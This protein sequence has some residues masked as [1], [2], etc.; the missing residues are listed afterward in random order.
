[1]WGLLF[2]SLVS[3]R[4]LA[5]AVGGAITPPERC[6]VLGDR[7]DADLLEAQFELAPFVR[8]RV[9]GFV[10]VPAAGDLVAEAN[11]NGVGGVGSNGTGGGVRLPP[12]MGQI[13]VEEE[14][15]RVIIARPPGALE[16]AD[17]LLQ[18]LRRLRGYG[19]RGQPPAAG[20][21]GRR[22][23]GRPRSATR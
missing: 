23:E 1:M 12:R 6:L 7:A 11:G 22:T 16:G 8:A 15:D 3:L 9:V 21:A 20:A 17:A 10:P 2:A 13:L 5:R 19:V 14:I 4:A 18:T